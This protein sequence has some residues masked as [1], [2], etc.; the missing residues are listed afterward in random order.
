M[1]LKQVVY[2]NKSCIIVVVVVVRSSSSTT[3]AST[4][5]RRRCR[6]HQNMLHLCF[7]TFVSV[8]CRRKD[9]DSGWN[10]V[11]LETNHSR[12]VQR[13]RLLEEWRQYLLLLKLQLL[14][15]LLLIM[16]VLLIIL[17]A[18]ATVT[19]M[20]S[21]TV[22]ADIS[23][24]SLLILPGHDDMMIAVDV[25][26]FLWKIGSS[27]FWWKQRRWFE[28]V[29][30]WID[31]LMK[32]NKIQ[33]YD[34]SNTTVQVQYGRYCSLVR[35]FLFFSFFFFFQIMMCDVVVFCFLLAYREKHVFLFR[36]RQLFYVWISIGDVGFHKNTTKWHERSYSIFQ[37]MIINSVITHIL[38]RHTVYYYL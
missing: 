37:A 9:F 17:F 28:I 14:L 5:R 35:L 16:L 8:I 30:G 25:M 10:L 3:T 24:R 21:D 11:R 1:L 19:D 2:V 15:L 31:G 34:R 32:K 4:R 6:C 13:N 27:L 7:E 26:L 36:K 38:L 12:V 18:I 29:D 33:Y 23:K 22:V 20:A